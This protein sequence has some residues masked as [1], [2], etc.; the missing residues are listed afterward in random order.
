MKTTKFFI[1]LTFVLFCFVSCSDDDAN[2]KEEPNE[3][4]V[5]QIDPIP[6][7]V[8]DPGEES[9]AP[10]IPITTLD[11]GIQIEGASKITGTPPEP[12]GTL[13]FNIQSTDQAGYLDTGFTVNF[14]STDAVAGAYILFKDENGVK[15]DSYFNVPLVSGKSNTSKKTKSRTSTTISSK[16][17]GEQ[18]IEVLF[19][20]NVPTG[21]FCYE[22]C[23]YDNANNISQIVSRCVTISSWGGNSSL[24]GD[25]KFDRSF[26]N[27]ELTADEDT[28][29]VTCNN[30]TVENFIDILYETND[31]ILSLEANGDYSE[32]YDERYQLLD[33]NPTL[34]ACS[35]IYGE[36]EESNDRYLG[37][38][39]YNETSGL[40][41]VDFAYENI[42]DPS[43]NETYERGE[44]Y[45]DGIAAE[46]VNGE[47]VLT[48][49]FQ[50]DGET[51]VAQ[52]IFVA[53]N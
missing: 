17:V 21:T 31:W 2:N 36:F 24:V 19:N 47:L 14:T 4:T 37:K 40:S 7:P 33:L 41:I 26:E 51:I 45:F 6:D 48:E 25:W 9:V 16:K 50:E 42:L 35:P 20:S 38:W 30:G 5:D 3:E 46:I 23:L 18:E 8:P 28:T 11:A 44:I 39:S 10:D 49:T 53:N 43:E 27:G 52:A 1:T 15:S 34:N 13:D 22:I 12:S 32:E 29:E